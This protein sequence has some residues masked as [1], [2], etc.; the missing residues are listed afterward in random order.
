[1]VLNGA[2][3][4][5][6]GAGKYEHITPVLRDILHWLPVSQRIEYKIALLTFNCIRGNGP[7]YLSDVCVPVP[8]I[9]S[10]VNLSSADRGDLVVP[11]TRTS[12][13]GR[14]SVS[15]TALNIWNSLPIYLRLPS[16]SRAQFS[17][18]LKTHLFR[19]AYR[20]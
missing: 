13:F 8:T 12:K 15:F 18:G 11:R 14:R 9:P 2:A 3:R 6:V 7:S 20:L 10:R 17:G 1:M 16:I 19:Q 5:V 4:L